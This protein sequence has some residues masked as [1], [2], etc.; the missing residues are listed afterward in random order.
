MIKRIIGWWKKP[1]KT[2]KHK[3]DITIFL[4]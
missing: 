3:N 1:L 2:E 4:R